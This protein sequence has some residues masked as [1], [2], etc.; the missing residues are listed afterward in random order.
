MGGC[1]WCLRLQL[2]SF[3]ILR[4]ESGMGFPRMQAISFRE[5]M[6]WT[7]TLQN[8]R[9][10]RGT[11]LSRW[12]RLK[13]PISECNITFFIFLNSK[14]SS[15]L[16]GRLQIAELSFCGALFLESSSTSSFLI[17]LKIGGLSITAK[18][19]HKT[20]SSLVCHLST[21]T[22]SA[23]RGRFCSTFALIGYIEENNRR[24][25]SVPLY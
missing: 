16:L 25:W 19:P 10:R 4:I 12:V 24:W 18:L 2:E 13:N 1:G 22:T 8:L 17:H 23:T 7:E 20:I 14:P 15:L 3:F 21:V 5:L 6:T 9:V 11:Y